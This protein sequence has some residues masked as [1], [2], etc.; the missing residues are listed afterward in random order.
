MPTL[1]SHEDETKATP[2]GSRFRKVRKWFAAIIAAER[3]VSLFQWAST[4]GVAWFSG[5]FEFISGL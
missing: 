2:R 4:D 3:I 1:C 5:L